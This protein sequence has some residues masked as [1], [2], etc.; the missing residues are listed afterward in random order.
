MVK[1]VKRHQSRLCFS[2]YH[3]GSTTEAV[4]KAKPLLRDLHNKVERLA[5]N[6][7][8]LATRSLR[9]EKSEAQRREEYLVR[10]LLGLVIL[11]VWLSLPSGL[12]VWASPLDPIRVFV[13]L[14]P[15][16]SG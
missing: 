8:E 4:L 2:V 14:L 11:I 7:V 12:A 16:R 13:L 10:L 5:A 9:V 1:P 3:A 6:I 15:S